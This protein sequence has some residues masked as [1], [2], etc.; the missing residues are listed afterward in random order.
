METVSSSSQLEIV[1]TTELECATAAL[2]SLEV[3]LRRSGEELVEEDL[4]A[5]SWNPNRLLIALAVSDMNAIFINEFLCCCSQCERERE[6]ERERNF[7]GWDLK[8]R[9]MRESRV[10]KEKSG[11]GEWS[12]GGDSLRCNGRDG[13]EDRLRSLF[14]IFELW[15][16][17]VRLCG[18]VGC[19][20]WEEGQRVPF[21]REKHSRLLSVLII[22]I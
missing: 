14:Q 22:K 5:W 10:G 4:E 15:S 18:W 9:E 13:V 20:D 16:H 6:R 7:G 12:D 2:L 19:Y 17:K 3:D 21:R 1:R 11:K 8:F